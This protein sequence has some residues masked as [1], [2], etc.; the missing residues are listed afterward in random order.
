M[1]VYLY[2]FI[3][4]CQYNRTRNV[5]LCQVHSSHVHANHKTSLNYNSKQ[6]TSRWTVIT[7]CITMEVEPRIAKQYKCQHCCSCKHYWGKG[8]EDGR[9]MSLHRF[10]ADQKIA[11]PWR[12]KKKREKK[13]WFFFWGGAS[14]STSVMAW[15]W[16]VEGQWPR[17]RSECV[18]ME[19]TA[20]GDGKQA[21]ILQQQTTFSAHPKSSLARIDKRT[22]R[23]A[24][25]TRYRYNKSA[26]WTTKWLTIVFPWPAQIQFPLQ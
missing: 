14:Y 21:F 9:K 13:N 12:Q 16:S 22:A 25:N 6:I 23:A 5:L 15:W 26:L 4:K 7:L 2:N 8:M 17:Q 11:S 24:G 1:Y 3:G 19:T 20:G 18:E 10:L